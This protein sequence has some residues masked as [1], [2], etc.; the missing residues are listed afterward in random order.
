MEKL[1]REYKKNKMSNKESIQS[2]FSTNHRSMCSFNSLNRY[3][4][5][6]G[7]ICFDTVSMQKVILVIISRMHLITLLR[8][9]KRQLG[10]M[11]LA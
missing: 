1:R 10:S 7:G 2:A 3:S 9:L 6:Y 8:I 5:G 4:S 11:K